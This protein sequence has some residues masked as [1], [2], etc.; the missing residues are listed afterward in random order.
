MR[1]G[2]DLSRGPPAEGLV[3]SAGVGSAVGVSGGRCLCLAGCA[4]ERQ[5]AVSGTAVDGPDLLPMTHLPLHHH[6]KPAPSPCPA[7]VALF[8]HDTGEDGDI[9]GRA[10]AWKAVATE[11]A[12]QFRRAGALP[13]TNPRI[14]WLPTAKRLDSNARVHAC[15]AITSQHD[16]PGALHDRL[17]TSRRDMNLYMHASP[18]A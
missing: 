14:S 13:I 16:S 10:G 11:G 9:Y 4:V 5:V 3:M 12:A 2:G 15:Q 17:E 8:Q 6:T 1:G 7:A 18:R